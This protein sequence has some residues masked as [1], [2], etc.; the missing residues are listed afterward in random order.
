MEQ[1]LIVSV[2]VQ[3]LNNPDKR[4]NIFAWLTRQKAKIVFVQETF[5]TENYSKYESQSWNGKIYHNFSKSTHSKGVA[6][7]IHESLNFEIENIHKRDD[8]RAILINGK[9]DG[10]NISLCNV[11]A[12]NKTNERI[13]FFKKIRS[14]I[15]KYSD[16][17]NGVVLGGDLNCAI[18]ENDRVS[19]KKTIDP[20]RKE[21]KKMANLLQLVDAWY[22]KNTEPQYTY[23]DTFNN[24]KSRIDY[25]FISKNLEFMVK[26]IKLKK[27]PKKDPHKAVCMYLNFNTNK[28]GPGYWKLNSKFLKESAYRK[29]IE[30]TV[31]ECLDEG[32]DDHRLV[33]EYIKIQIKTV[34][35]R[36]G[37]QRAKKNKNNIDTL[38]NEL[39]EINK[40]EDLGFLIDKDRKYTLEEN[41]QKYYDEK[42]E[43]SKI[44]SKIRW[45]KDGEKC[46]S[47]FFNLEKDRQKSNIIKRLQDN[48]GVMHTDD[49]G[50]LNIGTDFYDDLFSS[51]NINQDTI[52][53]YLGKANINIKLSDSQKSD[54]DMDFDEKE[55][56]N[57]V[58]RLKPN[59]SPGIDG[60]I[61]E[62]Y[63]E[64]WDIIK[65]P[66]MSM[67]QDTYIHGELPYTL[68]KAIL[69]LLFKK[70][71]DFL[72][73]NYRPIS[74][75]NYDYKIIAFILAER[76]QK[77]IKSLI[78]KDQTGYVK[79]RF[80][81]TNARLIQDYFDFCENYQIPG[82][83]VCLDFEKAFD[84][85][86]WNFMISVLKKFNFGP[87]FIKWV[88]ILYNQPIISIKNNG[89]LS[90]DIYLKRGVRQGCPLS[91]L[92]FILSVEILAINIRNNK[93]IKGFKCDEST[94]KTSMYADDSTLLLENLD[95][96]SVALNVINDFS[97][98]AGPRL[99][100]NKTE[101]ILLGTLKNTIDMYN[102]VRFTNDSIR[103]LGIYVGH[104]KIGNH[105]NNWIKKIEKMDI[106]LERWKQRDLTIFGKSLIIKGLAISKM[107]YTMS[108]FSIPEEVLKQTNKLIFEFIWGKRDRIKRKTL[109]GTKLQGGIEMIDLECKNKALKAAWVGRLIKQCTNRLFLDRCLATYG[110]TTEY[111]ITS[112]VRNFS[113]YV[114]TLKIP[115]FWAEVFSSYNECKTVKGFDKMNTFD[116]L[117]QPIWLNSMF[118]HNNKPLLYQNWTKSNIFY[119]KDLF[120]RNGS[121]IS[122]TDI[123]EMLDNK[124]NWIS[125]YV[126]IKTLFK[127]H[128]DMFNT[129][130]AT[131]VNIKTTHTMLVNNN[132]HCIRDQKSK[133]Y[134]KILVNKKFY[135]NFMESK[136]ERDFTIDKSEWEGIYNRM[137]WSLPDK[138]I[139]EFNFKVLHNIVQTR[140]KICVWNR[141]INNQ[142]QFCY[143]KH[144]VF[145]LLYECV[146]IKNLWIIIGDSLNLDV[147]YRHIIIGNRDENNLT[148]ARNLLLSYIKFCFYKIWIMAENDKL[149]FKNVNVA[150]FL[151]DYLFRKS[152]II[153]NPVF[154]RL[155]DKVVSNL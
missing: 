113:I 93:D 108:I 111:L 117:S 10:C 97:K 100:M 59:K 144:S 154:K 27:A 49:S 13:D 28:K 87:K 120:N 52:N 106:L 152:C 19:N 101:G 25:F 134:Y 130:N 124:S 109:I 78:H 91:S 4:S 46:S 121:F 70:G 119:V 155:C 146:R 65:K 14:W 84:S 2:N 88:E 94:I 80:I 90:K 21:L 125:E 79:G 76:L 145:H 104:D 142:C 55:I 66:F 103:C 68:R 139:S 53:E 24:S 71:D 128:K 1:T 150:Q 135:R 41:I 12:P 36:Y 133:F 75:T 47:Y 140:E 105:Y 122:E 92:L 137:I 48:N 81:G 60:I 35:I 114:E 51:L 86:E 73:K 149:D 72:L 123:I 7:M 83:L 136:W 61:P 82:L 99:N 31:R 45:I 32:W 118:Q 85:L 56:K 20:S 5:C 98:V 63:K 40:N 74:L 42:R 77:V 148:K 33:W 115:T 17:P 89:W 102:G 64:F 3:G 54:C 37:I 29:L 62:F 138:K 44:R 67:V 34:S 16:N 116:F 26:K 69:A 23:Y 38:Q 11:Y 131:Y 141:N 39:D 110:I 112:N 58:N 96:L 6:I 43:G 15:A 30:H 50:I 18:N 143:Q 147:R 126:K 9:I 8:S 153:S 151:K 95:S 127:R 129:S 22:I 107:I 132:V 57:V